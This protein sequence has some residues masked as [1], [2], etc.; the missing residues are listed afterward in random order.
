MRPSS[1]FVA[2]TGLVIICLFMAACGGGSVSGTPPP[3]PPSPDFTISVSAA[4]IILTQGATGQ[5]LQISVIPKNGFADTVTVTTAGLPNG[6][7]ASPSSLSITPSSPGT[8][9]LAASN[10]A[11]IAQTPVAF[12]AVSGSLTA[13]SSVQVT[14]TGTAPPDPFHPVG[15]SM[16]HGFYDESRQLLFAPNLGLNELDV[17]SSVDFS[18]QH[19]LPLPQPFGIDQMADGKTLVI[20]TK[21]QQLLTVDE[22]TLAVTKHPFSAVGS[23][24]FSLSFPNVVALANGKVIVIGQE[25][26]IDSSNIIDGGQYLYVWDSIA[27]TFT[28]FEPTTSNPWETDS[29]VRS[30]DH[31]WAVFSGDQ[32]YLYSSDSNSSKS[33]PL[34][35]VDPP[36]DS[37]GVRGYAINSNGSEIAVVS[38]NQVTFLNSSLVALGTT[39]IPDAFQSVGTNVQFSADGSKLYV[40]FDGPFA[41][42]EIDATTFAILGSRSAETIPGGGFLDRLLATDSQGH[43]Y[44]GTGGGIRF[45]DLT[46]PPV[47]NDSSGIQTPNCPV[48]NASLPLNMSAQQTLTSTYAD[49]NVYIGA[50]AAPLLDGATV[51]SIPASSAVGPVDVQCVAPSGDT[52]IYMQGVSY[53]VQ[54]VGFSANFLPPTGNPSSYLFGFGFSGKQFEVPSVTIGGQPATNVADLQADEAGTLQGAGMQVPNGSAGDMPVISVSSSVGSGMLAGATSYYISPTII[55]AIGLIQLLYDTHR[56]VV[57]ALKATEVDVLDPVSLQWKSPI[58]FPATATGTFGMMAL[59]P[60][61]SKLV[62][63]GLTPDDH[64]QAIVLDPDGHVAPAVATFPT[65]GEVTGSIVITPSNKVLFTGLLAIELD[66]SSLTF[67]SLNITTGD[68][69]RSTPDGTHIYGVDLN[70]G[71]G[72]VYS[73]DPTTYVVQ[74]ESFGLLFW[75]DLAVSP[76][77]SQFSPINIGP[78]GAGDL[79]GFFDSALHLLNMNV[80]PAFSPP[81]DSGAI[82]SMYSPQGKVLVVPLGDSIEFWDAEAGTLRARLMTPEELNTIVFPEG[83]VPPVMALD[84]AG[85]TIYAISASGLTVFKLPQPIDQMPAAQWPEARAGRAKESRFQGSTL[86]RKAAVQGRANKTS[87]D[88]DQTS[89]P[90]P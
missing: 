68:L 50:Q 77:G 81:D 67:T 82:G 24:G 2:V 11:Q 13:D 19:R 70:V 78:E 7:T 38:A 73:I 23:G 39:P 51:L 61:G 75:T 90:R 1:G 83:A 47:P 46:Q 16:T 4:N 14:V 60:D 59:S 8:F 63:E 36:D 86:S 52:V 48:L 21:A 12:N 28:Q 34:S 55:P 87:V 29:L 22:N 26:G 80:Y 64:P 5:P 6:V 45:M 49:L 53:G 40:Q 89:K 10:S 43:A 72:E 32:F 20:G 54:A 58:S 3:P 18:V 27:N 88:P 15:G 9:T 57:Y 65:Q 37:F 74:D 79:V 62:V 25:E 44:V 84:P 42:E 56:K 30:T 66:L 35:V 71:S 33:V 31:K 76:D 85:Q 17:I 41:I 69:L